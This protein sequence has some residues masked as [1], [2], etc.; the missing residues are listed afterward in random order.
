VGCSLPKVLGLHLL[1]H[2]LKKQ[3]IGYV[4]FKNVN[5]NIE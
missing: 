1:A 4:S 5:S 2:F 3:G